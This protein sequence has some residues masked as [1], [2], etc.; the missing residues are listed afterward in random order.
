MSKGFLNSSGLKSGHLEFVV[1]HLYR[2]EYHLERRPAISLK[3]NN[4]ILD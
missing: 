1:S 4:I 3:E 2:D